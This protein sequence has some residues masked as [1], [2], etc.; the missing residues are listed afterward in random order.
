MTTARPRHRAQRTPKRRPPKPLALVRWLW[1]RYQLGW[2]THPIL[3]LADTVCGILFLGT[4]TAA[5]AGVL[6]WWTVAV[7]FLV[8]TIV[9]A[10]AFCARPWPA[11]PTRPT[12]NRDNDYINDIEP[13]PGAD[14]PS[15]GAGEESPGPQVRFDEADDERPAVMS[16]DRPTDR[17]R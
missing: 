17:A 1:Q 4:L 6:P 9:G 10:A 11:F 7:V 5:H 16:E 8:G 2:R 3:Y 15:G 14:T 13:C 12:N